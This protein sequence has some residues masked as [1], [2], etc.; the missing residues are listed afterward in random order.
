[1]AS[2]T[3]DISHG[4]RLAIG[5]VLLWFGGVCLFVAFLS[6]K[7]SSLTASTDAGGTGHGPKDVSELVSS[8]AKNVQAAEQ[9]SGAIIGAQAAG[10]GL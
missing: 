2:L 4:T 3:S 5:I 7:I 10:T 8:V 9:G 6:G 1:M